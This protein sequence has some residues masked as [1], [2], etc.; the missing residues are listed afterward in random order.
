MLYYL[1]DK[2]K[3]NFLTIV[4]N[5]PSLTTDYAKAKFFTLEKVQNICK[6]LNP[7]FSNMKIFEQEHKGMT[8]FISD[9]GDENYADC[10]DE[11]LPY[12]LDVIVDIIDDLP[13]KLENERV[14]LNNLL[15]KLSR[16]ATDVNH[17]REFNPKRP[18][19]KRCQLDVFETQVLLKR[20]EIKDKLYL[21]DLAFAKLNGKNIEKV[22]ERKYTPR[23]LNALFDEDIIPDFNKWWKE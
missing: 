21:I 4:N 20:R 1:A 13:N 6:N 17:Y 8:D 2:N 16:A 5:Q 19:D 9:K 10:K 22:E 12:E 7:S 23:E 11:K 15:I 14:R 18:A 3:K